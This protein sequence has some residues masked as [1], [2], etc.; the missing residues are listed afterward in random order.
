M[1]RFVNT[2][3]QSNSDQKEIWSLVNNLRFEYLTKNIQVKC[4]NF[5]ENLSTNLEKMSQII[6]SVKSS[7]QIHTNL[8]RMDI[9][10]VAKMF[11]YLN[12]CPS[13]HEKLYFKTIYGPESRIAMLTSNIIKKANNDFKIKAIQIFAKISQVFGFQHITPQDK[14]ENIEMEINVTDKKLL[15]TI[16]NHPVHILDNEE[17][18]SPSSFIPFCSFGE[19]FIGSKVNEFDIPVCNIFKPRIYFDQIC[20]EA[21][22]QKLKESKKIE[23]QLELGLTLVLDYNEERQLN[24]N[25]TPKKVSNGLKAFY[26]NDGDSVS[27]YLD[28][29]SM[30]YGSNF[31]TAYNLY[32]DPVRLFGEGQFNLNNMKEISVTDSFLGL[33]RDT[34]NCQNIETYNDCKTRLYVDTLRKECG[35]LPL[36]LKLSEKVNIINILGSERSHDA[37][38]LWG[39]FSMLDFRMIY[40]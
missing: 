12:S 17:E 10:N 37:L 25:V 11:I 18:F 2:V 3:T 22:L 15:Q 7:E 35:C 19:E 4:S 6:T 24:F 33:S 31:N 30:K 14:G 29:I 38:C 1:F 28:T 8:S 34:R 36:S 23:E 32:V 21:D 20:Y 16:S 40:A 39:L 5:K 13:F 27:I 9:N 26:N